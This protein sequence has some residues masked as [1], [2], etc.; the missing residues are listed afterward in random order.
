ML[1]QQSYRCCCFCSAQRPFLR[2][3]LL[4]SLPF[5]GSS[6]YEMFTPPLSF[7]S[8]WRH[9]SCARVLAQENRTRV[10]AAAVRRREIFSQQQQT[11]TR[12]WYTIMSFERRRRFFFPV[13]GSMR[14]S[15]GRTELINSKTNIMYSYG[16]SATNRC[17]VST[18]YS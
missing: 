13:E 8:E 17:S 10:F 6:L 3:C 11:M 2:S 9:E 16:V 12:S 14:G 1:Q 5:F 15:R 4:F 18:N 7:V